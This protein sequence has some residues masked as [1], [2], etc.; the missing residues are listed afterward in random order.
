[1]KKILLVALACT[2]GSCSDLL[3][4]EDSDS[5]KTNRVPIS[6]EEVISVSFDDP[7]TLSEEDAI[8]MAEDFGESVSFSLRSSAPV[9]AEISGKR[10]LKWNDS[11]TR[12]AQTADSILL[13]TV[14]LT[15]GEKKGFAIVSAD[16]RSAGVMAYVEEGDLNDIEGTGAD[17]ML[18]LSEISVM[19]DVIKVERLRDSLRDA[20]LAK[21]SEAAGQEVTSFNEIRSLINIY[22]DNFNNAEYDINVKSTP[23]LRST[24]VE[25]PKS[26]VEILIGPITK[27]QWSQ[28]DPYSF[29]LPQSYHPNYGSLTHYPAGCAIVAGVQTLAAVAPNITVNGVYVDWSYLT[30]QPYIRYT[31]YG[32]GDEK[33]MNM[34]ATVV[35]DMYE[36][37]GTTPNIDTGYQYSSFQDPSIPCVLSST[38]SVPKLIDYLN[39]YVSCGKYYNKYAPDPL[40]LSINANEKF[41]CVAIMGASRDGGKSHAWIIDG[42]AVCAKTTREILRNNDLYFHANMGWSGSSDGYYKVNEDTSTDFET[43]QGNYNLNFWEITEIHRK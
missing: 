3:E 18:K 36:Q 11:R 15:K 16:E 8:A 41:P 24:P 22:C 25:Y 23:S 42:Y 12:S 13:Y 1:M 14:S 43:A 28:S 32:G 34:V 33:G 35:K 27:T 6:V 29:Y 19:A 2:L 9:K 37:T 4:P 39:R 38:T 17:M 31:S 20:T 30:A 40:I 5:P 10:L 26:A 7:R 21:L